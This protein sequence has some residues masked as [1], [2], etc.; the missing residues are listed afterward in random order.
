MFLNLAPDFSSQF[1]PT[2]CSDIQRN[3]E[4]QALSTSGGRVST[5]AKS[6]DGNN[7]LTGGVGCDEWT[8]L[9]RVLQEENA[10]A[11]VSLCLCARACNYTVFFF[12][13][14]LV[15]RIQYSWFENLNVKKINKFQCMWQIY[16]TEH[17]WWP[18]HFCPTG[19]ATA[20]TLSI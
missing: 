11:Q 15:W 8:F 1:T 13:L 16:Q 6:F 20:F 17:M 7:L 12:L 19:G 4:G 2:V 14:N 9:I 3:F 5:V 10:G 18:L